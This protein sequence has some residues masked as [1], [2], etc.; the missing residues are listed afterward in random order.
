MK[1]EFRAAEPSDVDAAVPLI[2]SSGPGAFTFVFKPTAH[3]DAQQ[4][5][6]TAF[7]DGAGEFGFRNHV[8]AVAENQ[9]VGIGAAF[10]GD[11]T[12]PFFIA[13]ARQI[14]LVY[15][16]HFFRVARNGL[17]VERIVAQPLRG[18]H[19]IGHLGVAPA[20]RSQGIGAQLIQTL[21]AQGKRAGRGIAAL[22][23][24]DTNPRA[25]ELYERIG[26]R[27]R[28]EHPSALQN[29]FAGVPGH[30]RMEKII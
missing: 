11:E 3:H 14:L 22:D 15:G 23:V 8:V 28:A 2:F 17:Q 5:L 24:A 21:I 18:V 25:Q 27:V 19:Y 1:I 9:V 12:I 10:S 16:I 20:Y 26:F 6:R 4:F 29:E 30:R 7:L 13:A